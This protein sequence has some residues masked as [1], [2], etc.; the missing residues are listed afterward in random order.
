MPLKRFQK[1]RRY[2]HFADNLQ[3]DGY[4]YFKVRHL[5]ESIRR[6]CLNVEEETRFS[7]DEI[8][9]PYKGARAG[10]RKQY[11]KNKP[12]KWGFKVFVRAGVPG[13]VYNFLVYGGQDTFH[14]SEFT[15]EEI[16][17]GLGA[18]VVLAISKTIKQ[19]AC[20]VL[21]FDNFFT[22]LELL[23]H[24]RN[25]PKRKLWD[26]EAKKK[27][28]EAVRAKE[29]GY[30]KTVKLFNVP[31]ATLKDYVKKPDKS[32]EEI[33]SGKMGKKPVLPLN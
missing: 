8:M 1:I 28:V 17:M 23:N 20:S 5:L 22:S 2:L 15:D 9:V 26:P 19:Q 25:M 27:A 7:I 12:R 4:R 13:I 18:K 29:M 24:L 3:D 10:S 6:N 32:I 14:Y 33:V 30:K 31:R 21:Y 11:I 16:C